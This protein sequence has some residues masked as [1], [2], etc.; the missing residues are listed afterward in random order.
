MKEVGLALLAGV[1]VGFVF[2]LIKLPLPA[3]PVL[4]GI[5]GIVGIYFGGLLA[6]RILQLFQ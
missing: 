5:M 4:A 1:I 2:K 3:P 6:D